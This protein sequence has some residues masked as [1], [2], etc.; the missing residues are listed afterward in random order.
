MTESEIC[1]KH[2]K[3]KCTE[4]LQESVGGC[5]KEFQ[6][7]SREPKSRPNGRQRFPQRSIVAPRLCP[8]VLEPTLWKLSLRNLRS[9]P[10]LHTATQK[11]PGESQ[12]RAREPKRGPRGLERA[13]E[14][15][16][17]EYSGA[18]APKKLP[19]WEV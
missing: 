17:K 16:L 7:R 18:W 19:K 6:E 4:A 11:V 9:D 3:E 10:K 5:A 12:A 8:S 1:Q 2:K 13:P 14:T 15:P